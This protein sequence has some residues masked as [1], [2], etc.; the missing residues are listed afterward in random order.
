VVFIL[1]ID[2]KLGLQ[3]EINECYSDDQLMI[4]KTRLALGKVELK[5][6]V[7]AAAAVVVTHGRIADCKRNCLA[8]AIWK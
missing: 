8:L 6:A 4:D 5:L 2:S 3:Q 7:A 1:Q